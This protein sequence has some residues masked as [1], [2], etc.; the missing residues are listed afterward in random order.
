MPITEVQ[1]RIGLSHPIIQGPFGG[2][3]STVELAAA[4]AN[5]GGLGS[6]GAHILEPDGIDALAADLRAATD[7]PVALNLWISDHDP[8]G[9]SLS[10]DAYDAVWPVFQ[11]FFAEYGLERPEPQRRYHPR[12]V[13]Q[14][15]AVLE[16]RPRVFSFVFGIPD[17]SILEA[18]RVRDILTLGA[19]TT[20]AEAEALD[21]AGID[22]IL[23]TGFEAGGH[24]PAFLEPPEN[25]LV[26]TLP[27]TR[28]IAS[29]IKRPLIAA[30]GI[31]DRGGID[32]ALTL[33]AGAAQLGTAFLACA[34][35]GTNNAHRDVLFSDRARQTVLTRAYTGR[36]AR[37]I[38]N[39]V[40][41]EMEARADRLPPFPV[42]AWFLGHLK[43]AALAA[44]DEDFASLYAGQGA[45]LL[46]HRRVGDLMADLTA[47]AATHVAA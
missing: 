38:P 12:F 27:L 37:G 22:L 23:A 29:R 14:V 33:G 34:E 19:A 36:L 26:G 8:G 10:S 4:V 13:D 24:R 47:P 15:D 32:A 21:A 17:R 40:I 3:L 46:Q 18:C 31:A 6:F 20:L 28:Q 7:G 11:P 44:G 39:R 42:Q 43:R 30:G 25:N 16:A 2:G 41:A 9:D 45:P 5:A 35:S 1:Q